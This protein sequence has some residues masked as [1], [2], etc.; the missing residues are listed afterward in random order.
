MNARFHCDVIRQIVTPYICEQRRTSSDEFEASA[1]KQCEKS[2]GQSP[3]NGG[4]S[5]AR[6]VTPCPGCGKENGGAAKSCKHCGK[7]FDEAHPPKKAPAV[8]ASAKRR[9]PSSRS[10]GDHDLVFKL[11]ERRIDLEQEIAA[12]DTALEMIKKYA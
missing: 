2:G 5:M 6:G 4:E 7:I 9:Q 8:K 3:Q 1:C 10:N 12:I 11:K